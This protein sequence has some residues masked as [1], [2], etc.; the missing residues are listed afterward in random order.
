MAAG[1]ERICVVIGRTRHKMA[2]VEIQEAAK[3]G[4]RLLELRL[5]FI[6]KAPDIKRLVADKRCA[7]IATIRRPGDGGR[8]SGSEDARQM[9]LKQCI[10]SGGFDW[11]D[12]ESDV[13]DQIRR[14]K[15]VKRIVSY[16]N[17]AEFP[18]NL[19]EIYARMCKQDADVLKLVV[20]AQS[21]RDNLRILELLKKAKRPT[22]A[23]CSGD[24]GI[25]SRILC[26]K[27]GAPY[28]YA[29]F[30][31]ERT[32][33]PGML[34]FEDLLRIYQPERINGETK[35]FGV[36]GDPIA[37]SHSPLVHNG[38][39]RQLGVNALYLPFRVPRGQL[40]GFLDA[41]AGI[42]V[43]GYSVTIPHK[44]A[45]AQAAQSRDETVTLT[46]AANTLVRRP[47][48]FH[49]ANTDYQ[50]ILDA[51]QAHVGTP[52]GPPV[53]LHKRMVL[54]LGAGGVARAVAH[55]LHRAGANVHISNRTLER[56]ERLAAEIDAEALDWNARHREGCDLVFNCTPIGMHPNVDDSP[57]HASYLRPGMVVFDTV[58]NPETT[59]L[60]REAK[61]RGAQVITGIDMFI[62]QAGLQFKLFTGLEPP[63]EAMATTL[64][65]E[66]SPVRIHDAD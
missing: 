20:A 56:A 30:N 12:L 17:L 43:D 64:R 66:L 33:V 44:E 49:A 51:L 42:P 7:L 31:K 47:E 50:A 15:D 46:H 18:A 35:V 27:Y 65:R 32:F 57:V 6:A 52:G 54:I 37:H 14:F 62:R 40:P 29:S 58:Y 11:V 34:S 1:A 21:L 63:I 61:A 38:A 25:P 53:N 39:F 23:F 60:I 13:A 48:G 3:R 19:D 8:W 2:V 28:T 22:I 45:A 16:H 41:F 26:L 24:L 10:V 59:M 4:A 55:A 9:L 5:D 36:I